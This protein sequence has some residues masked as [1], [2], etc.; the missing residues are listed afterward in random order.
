MC[1]DKKTKSV[2]L[3]RRVQG[4]PPPRY[5]NLLLAKSKC[6]GLSESAIVTEAVKQYFDSMPEQERQRITQFSKNSY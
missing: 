2:A 1:E 3:Q 6:D 5:H 4:Y